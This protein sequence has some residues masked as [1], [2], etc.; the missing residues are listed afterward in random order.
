[1][2]RDRYLGK[3]KDDTRRGCR[4]GGWDV[5]NMMK[6]GENGRKRNKTAGGKKGKYGKRELNKLIFGKN[7]RGR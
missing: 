5:G 1:L 3:L 6:G 2:V 4:E 7:G